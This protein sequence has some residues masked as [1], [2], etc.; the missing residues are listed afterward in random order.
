MLVR[1]AILAPRLVL[2]TNGGPDGLDRHLA[3]S[4]EGVTVR[5][6]VEFNGERGAGL[7][8][9]R[10]NGELDLGPSEVANPL[11]LGEENRVNGAACQGSLLG[12]GT[13]ELELRDSNNAAG[14][15]RCGRR[16]RHDRELVD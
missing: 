1:L 5:L 13:A 6:V 9:A 3:N 2:V 11:L 14:S 10:R 16:A 7:G 4:I 15:V 8:A 12:R